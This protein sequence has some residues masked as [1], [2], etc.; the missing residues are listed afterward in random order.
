M[1]D[2]VAVRGLSRVALQTTVVYCAAFVALGL[3]HASLGPTLMGLAAQVGTG[4]V[5]ISY[6][7]SARSA[8]YLTG[9][10]IG[11]RLYDAVRGHPVLALMLMCIGVGLATLPMVPVLALLIALLFAIGVAEAL[12]MWASTRLSSGCTVARSG[13]I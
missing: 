3:S 6:G 1:A 9:S 10:I 5:Q 2:R 11:G 4:L 13:P 8:G 7:L 12:L